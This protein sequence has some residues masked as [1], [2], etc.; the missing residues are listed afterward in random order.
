MTHDECHAT[1]ADLNADGWHVRIDFA[2]DRRHIVS[3]GLT[4]DGRST[5]DWAGNDYRIGVAKLALK[6]ARGEE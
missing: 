3:V 2:P 1:I 5:P 4:P 6:I